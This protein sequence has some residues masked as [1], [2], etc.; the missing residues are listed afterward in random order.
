MLHACAETQ[1]MR[2]FGLFVLLLVVGTA[3]GYC[4]KKGSFASLLEAAQEAQSHSDYSTAVRYYQSAAA[5]RPGVAELWSN[6]GL[7]QDVTGDYKVA[8][9]SFQKAV[10]LKPQLYVPNLFLGIDYLH[11]G[12][13]QQAISSLEKAERLN[14]RDARAPLTLGRAYLSLRDYAAASRAYRRSIELDPT[15]ASAWFD[16]G[17]AALNEVETGG[18]MLSDETPNSPYA[19][20]LYAESL[21]EQLRYREAIAEMHAA[22]TV[23]P[24]FTCAHAQLGLLYLAEQQVESAAQE[25]AAEAPNCGLTGLGQ[26]QLRIDA[27]DDSGALSLLDALWK[28]DPGFVRANAAHLVENLPEDRKASFADFVARQNR[29]TVET[30]QTEL[31]GVLTAALAGRSQDE[32]AQLAKEEPPSMA[33]EATAQADLSAGHYGACVRDLSAGAGGAGKGTKND[34]ARSHGLEL[35]LAH[36]AFMT[37]DYDLAATVSDRAATQSP[38][39]AAARYW[40]VKAN[41][42]LAFRA[43]SRFGELD[44]NS[45]RTHLMLGDMYRQRQRFQQAESEYKE[46]SALAPQDAAPLFGLASA[47]SQDS[48]EDEAL[49]IARTARD[50]NPD[51]PDFNLL[52]GEILVGRHAWTEA[53]TYLNR[54]NGVKT[55]MLPHLH[56]LL[57]EVYEH[58]NRPKQ[59]IT[60]LQMG[61]SSDETGGAYY[62]LARLYMSEGKKTAAQ[63][64]LAH[65]KEL[66]KKRLAHAAIAVEDGSDAMQSDI[67]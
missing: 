1:I 37:G 38:Q 26:A 13:P 28:R 9:T 65:T 42:R 11:I 23:D 3:A 30:S 48:K 18:R 64:A 66:E 6:L 29:L 63:D 7:M 47:Y 17:V 46:A 33:T 51:D 34:A 25:F 58:T 20:A 43:F 45:E 19:R 21:G 61:A 5:L 22:L 15:N 12:Q 44:P 4:Q 57:G 49:T 53:E 27:G 59:A 55:Q 54:A 52:L 39:D 67:H 36:C 31:N 14:P 2:S 32:S 10:L 41:E 50:R 40:S 35:L 62:Q 24:H 8:I 56:I 60:E 16:F